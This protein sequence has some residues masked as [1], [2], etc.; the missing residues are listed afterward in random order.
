MIVSV[1]DINFIQI[2]LSSPEQQLNREA[3]SEG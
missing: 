3:A 2:L 1:E